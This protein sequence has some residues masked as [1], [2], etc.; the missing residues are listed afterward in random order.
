MGQ[1]YAANGIFRVP[2]N[3]YLGNK[4]RH[5]KKSMGPFFAVK[6]NYGVI[7]IKYMYYCIY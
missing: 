5:V 1:F 4:S 7:S 2:E 3:L 6:V